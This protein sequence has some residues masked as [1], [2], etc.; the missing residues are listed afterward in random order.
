MREFIFALIRLGKCP[1]YSFERRGIMKHDALIKL[2][3]V[4]AL[5][6]AT[7]AEYCTNY[8][9]GLHCSKVSNKNIEIS[10]KTYVSIDDAD[11]QIDKN[12]MDKFP[13]ATFLNLEE[14][15][16][17]I[18]DPG[19]KE[20]HPLKSLWIISCDVDNF[21]YALRRFRDLEELKISQTLIDYDFIDKDLLKNN[22]NLKVLKLNRIRIHSIEANAFDNL[23]NLNYIEI[24]G[25]DLHEI[26]VDLFKFNSHLEYLILSQNKF[27]TIPNIDYPQSLRTWNLYNNIIGNVSAKD[28][29]K[30]VNIEDLLLNLNRIEYIEEN[31]FH[32][33]KNIKYLQLA[34]NKLTNFS[35]TLF[36]D[37]NTL[38][39]LD[40]SYNTISEDA[41]D[42]L[43][44][45]FVI[46]YPQRVADLGDSYDYDVD[47]ADY[48]ISME[49]ED[50]DEVPGSN[51]TEDKELKDMYYSEIYGS[52]DKKDQRTTKPT[53]FE[54]DDEDLVESG[55]GH[56][57]TENTNFDITT[58]PGQGSKFSIS[59]GILVLVLFFSVSY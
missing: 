54:S 6:A 36:E 44:D 23:S 37:L 49:Q 55:S 22:R 7:S 59:S 51:S 3:K 25:T 2:L 5:T 28:F 11:L 19:T 1:Q 15:I 45:S 39:F 50:D 42:V 38:D 8:P 30:L 14:S 20:I 9:N 56:T 57:T 43:S 18:A 31:A 46:M 41:L 27:S 16:L 53:T 26:P 13:K 33:L 58:T 12:F 35:K 17:Y 32:E 29:E 4:I 48:F 34:S 24:T 40:V 21:T 52:G 47:N 10:N